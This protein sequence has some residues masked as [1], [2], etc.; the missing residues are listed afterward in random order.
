M[1]DLM[2]TKPSPDWAAE[3]EVLGRTMPMGRLSAGTLG[4]G[5][6][7]IEAVAF[8]QHPASVRPLGLPL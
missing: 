8:H 5:D 4:L 3:R 7:I 6:G 2:R 1:L